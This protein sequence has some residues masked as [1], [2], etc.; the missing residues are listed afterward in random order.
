MPIKATPLGPS[1]SRPHVLE[2]SNVQPTAIGPRKSLLRTVLFWFHL[3]AGLTAGTVIAVMALTGTLLMFEKQISSWADGY[4]VEPPSS[5]VTVSIEALLKSAMAVRPSS[6]PSSVT[7]SADRTR[8][9]SI[10]LGRDGT[11]FLNPYTADAFGQGAQEVRAFFRSVTDWHRWL[12][13]SG[14]RRAIGRSI[15]GAANLLF[16]FIVVSG[17]FIWWPRSWNAVSLRSIVLFRSGIRGKARD[18]NWHNAIGIWSAVPLFFVVATAVVISYPWAGDL[19]YRVTGGEP[20]P[21]A[22]APSTTPPAAAAR[23]SASEVSPATARPDVSGLDALWLVATKQAP[24][25]RSL[26]F[27]IPSSRNDPVTVSIDTSTGAVRP[28]KRSQLVLDRA[29]GR[30]IRHD[31]Y[32]EQVAGRKLRTWARWVHTGEAFGL[33]GQ[34]MAGLASAGVLFLAWTGFALSWRRFR[35]FLLRRANSRRVALAGP[36]PDLALTR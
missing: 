19:L 33:P 15:T 29:S 34:L 35:A 27:R 18:F 14:E 32:D 11:L 23:S 3:V 13:F 24:D 10:G 26:N 25:W 1:P 12:A 4:R 7:V 17:P 16:L 22:P 30:V 31:T 2:G 21:R 5:E 28:D 9:A 6:V 8:P 36:E 20:P